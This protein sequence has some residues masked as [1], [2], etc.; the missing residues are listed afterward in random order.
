M[1]PSRKVMSFD[2]PKQC[3]SCDRPLGSCSVIV[4]IDDGPWTCE[5]CDG[6]IVAKEQQCQS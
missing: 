5:V 4:R 1:K 3:P 6:K 2:R